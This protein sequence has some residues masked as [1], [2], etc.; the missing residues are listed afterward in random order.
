MHER[1]SEAEGTQ[2]QHSSRSQTGWSDST[3]QFAVE[4]KRVKG[5]RALGLRRIQGSLRS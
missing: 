4:C 3:Q 2:T 1:C 5:V